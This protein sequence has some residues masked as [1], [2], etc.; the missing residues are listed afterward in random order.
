MWLYHPGLK[1][2]D[3]ISKS[4][5]RKYRK[6]KNPEENFDFDDSKM[7]SHSSAA[8]NRFGQLNPEKI[9]WI[10]AG[11]VTI[12]LSNLY[13]LILPHQWPVQFRTSWKFNFLLYSAYMSFSAFIIIFLYLNYYLRYFCGVKITAKNWKRDAPISVPAATI[14]GSLGFILLFLAF[15]PH[16]HLWS[17]LIFPILFMSF[18]ALISLF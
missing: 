5:L 3:S 2:M 13:N 1:F 17:L 15:L 4:S 12:Y 8:V 9:A 16:F 14:S 6:L 7:N 10:L 18:F 11:L